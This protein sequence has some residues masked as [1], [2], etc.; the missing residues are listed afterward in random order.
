MWDT[1][2][3]HT[4]Q[5]GHLSHDMPCSSCGHAMH[6]Y[7]RCN[8]SCDCEPPCVPGAVAGSGQRLALA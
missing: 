1:V 2:E 6:T 7:L 5:T 8:D 3:E 4:G